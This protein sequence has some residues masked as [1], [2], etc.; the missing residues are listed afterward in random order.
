MRLI[1]ALVLGLS[2]LACGDGGGSSGDGAVSDAE[3]QA[4]CE[5]GVVVCKDDPR[6]GAFAAMDCSADAIAE[7]YMG[8]DD[9]CRA[10]AAP[11]IECQTAAADCAAFIACVGGP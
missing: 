5:N 7:A 4:A 9:G 1:V 2:L 10:S 6:G 8:C 11:I 3:F